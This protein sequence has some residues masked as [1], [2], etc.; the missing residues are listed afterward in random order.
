MPMVAM[1]LM[2]QMRVI[3]QKSLR[4]STC[5]YSPGFPASGRGSGA[6]SQNNTVTIQTY[7]YPANDTFNVYMNYFGTRGVGGILVDTVSSGSGG[8]MSFTFNIPDSLKG[9]YQ[10][11]IRLESPTSGYYSY[12]W[13]YNNTYP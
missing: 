13:F 12:N 11:A 8:S 3:S 6:V 5:E 7:N 9:L 2:V 10:I 1:L 4:R